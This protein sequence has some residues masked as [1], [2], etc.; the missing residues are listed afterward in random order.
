ME[1]EIRFYFSKKELNEILNKLKEIKELK[2]SGRFYEKTIQ[3]NTTDPNNDF[4]SKEIDGRFRLRITKGDNI[5]KSMLSWKRRLKDTSK[6]RINKEE[7]KET[8]INP[9]D[10]DNFIYVVENVL[11]MNRVES[12]E[13]YRN[14]FI[15]EE[16]EIS[17]DEYPFGIALEIESKKESN[18]EEI[19]DKYV[20]LLNL[21]YEDSYRLSWDDKYAELCKKNSIEIKKDVLF[22]DKTIPEL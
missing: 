16:V 14:N 15:N 11:K 9:E 20:K 7:E 2:Y 3:Y 22:E 17:V 4:Y 8:R 5:S 18:Q 21:K 19:I 10:F 13:R 12:Y 6:G 1:Y